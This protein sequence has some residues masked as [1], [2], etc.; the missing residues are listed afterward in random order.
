MPHVLHARSTEDIQRCWPVLRDL[1]P[2]LSADGLVEAVRRM[3]PH[4]FHLVMLEDEDGEVRAVAGYRVTEMLRTGRMLE[5]DDL[6][7]DPLARSRGHGRHLFEWLVA[8]A[9]RQ[10]CSVLELDSA[11]HRHE[12]HRFYFRQRMRILG[13]HF[14]LPCASA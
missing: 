6:V 2:D 11:V 1:R 3:T 14:S 4:G 13:Y 5:V 12:A 9:G 7:T 8:E 10:G